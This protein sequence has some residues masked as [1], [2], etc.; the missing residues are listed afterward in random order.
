[1][2]FH[3]NIEQPHRHKQQGNAFNVR[4]AMHV[5]GGELVVNK[6]TRVDGTFVVLALSSLAA[7]ATPV[8]STN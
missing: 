3:V 7:W 5:P 2:R 1:M 4:I 8:T 6:K